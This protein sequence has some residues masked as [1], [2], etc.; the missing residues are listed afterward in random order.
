MPLRAILKGTGQG[1]QRCPEGIPWTKKIE[2][3]NAAAPKNAALRMIAVI[4]KS[5]SKRMPATLSAAMAS[6]GKPP[7]G[8]ITI[9]PPK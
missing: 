9:K 2:N 5:K 4:Q 7:P 3:L 1:K 6:A 8:A